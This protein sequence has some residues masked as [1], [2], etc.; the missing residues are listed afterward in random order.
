[1]SSNTHNTVKRPV[2]YW[3]SGTAG[4]VT[5]NRLNLQQRNFKLNTKG[6]NIVM[7]DSELLKLRD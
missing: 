7:K 1:M 2:G 5:R 6:R 4:D 3:F